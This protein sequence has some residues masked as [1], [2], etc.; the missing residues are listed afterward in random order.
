MKKYIRNTSSIYND[1]DVYDE[2][3]DES[4]YSNIPIYYTVYELNEDGDEVESVE[5]FE[6]LNKAIDF[7][8]SCDFST[9]IC[10]VPEMD[11]DDDPGY[12]EYIEYAY[13]YEPYEV[14]WSSLD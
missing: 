2:E 1:D 9:H 14:V 11:P 7:A 8:K 5:A 13:D 6:S 12:A 10:F 4:E 3:F